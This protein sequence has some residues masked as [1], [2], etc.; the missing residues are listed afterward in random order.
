LD[1]EMGTYTDLIKKQSQHIL[2]EDNED[3]D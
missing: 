3:E 2:P 1:P